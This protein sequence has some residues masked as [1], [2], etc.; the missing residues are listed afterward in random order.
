MCLCVVIPWLRCG[1]E[2]D[3]GIA[4]MLR[5]CIKFGFLNKICIKVKVD[6]SAQEITCS[7]NAHSIVLHRACM[8]EHVVHQK[9]QHIHA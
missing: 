9:R 3:Q 4:I 2:S 1:L 6:T 8:A 5:E 7:A